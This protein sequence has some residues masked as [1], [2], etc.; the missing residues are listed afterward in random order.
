M[1]SATRLLLLLLLHVFFAASSFLPSLALLTLLRVLLL[2]KRSSYSR[3]GARVP[4]DV[5]ECAEWEWEKSWP[6]S[7][8]FFSFI[9]GQFSQFSTAC[10]SFLSSFPPLCRFNWMSINRV[11]SLFLPRSDH[12]NHCQNRSANLWR[13]CRPLAPHIMAGR[14]IRCFSANQI[15]GDDSSATEHDTHHHHRQLLLPAVVFGGGR[16]WLAGEEFIH[17]H[18][19]L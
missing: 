10:G 18:A 1:V 7:W 8:H 15:I 13:A 14:Q 16:G 17:D 9:L 2:L 4:V 3:L 12:M 19:L 6:F 11:L 5:D